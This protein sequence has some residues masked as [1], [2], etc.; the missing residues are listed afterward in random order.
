MAER[1]DTPPVASGPSKDFVGQKMR[2]DDEGW[3]FF[4]TNDPRLNIRALLDACS[5]VEQVSLDVT[6]LIH[7]GYLKFGAHVCDEA[8]AATSK[9]PILEPTIIIGEGSSDIF[10]LSKSVSRS[11]STPLRLLRIL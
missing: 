9:R 8:R 5:D 3:L 2:H 1:W 7:G 10:I 11:V 4:P 6:D